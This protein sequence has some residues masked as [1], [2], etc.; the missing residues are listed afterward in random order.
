MKRVK[1]PLLLAALAMAIA[2]Q[3]AVAQSTAAT[4]SSAQ[5][6]ST[7]QDPLPGNNAD[8]PANPALA[9]DEHRPWSR[10]RSLV[11]SRNPAASTC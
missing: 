10:R 4:P 3:P 9:L 5:S 2:I 11:R 6:G 7:A 8:Q 1:F